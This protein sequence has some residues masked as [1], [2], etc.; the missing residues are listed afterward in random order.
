MTPTLASAA[1][2][3]RRHRARL[4]FHANGVL[5][6]FPRY[7][8]VLLLDISLAGA[9]L[10]LRDDC[11]VR[12]HEDCVLRIVSAEG[13][14]LIEVEAATAHCDEHGHVGLA[15]SHVTAG[16][17]QALRTLFEMNLATES[18]LTR[19]LCALLQP[20]AARGLA[21]QQSQVSAR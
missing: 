16:A 12:E 14:Q 15:F 4:P 11:D 3:E 5:I 20:L 7:A 2:A 9:H 10:L 17:A 13:R 19:D 21:P 8:D 18:L 6:L 1:F